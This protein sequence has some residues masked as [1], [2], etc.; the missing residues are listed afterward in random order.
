MRVVVAGLVRGESCHAFAVVPAICDRANPIVFAVC[1][2][3]T[4]LVVWGCYALAGA[5]FGSLDADRTAWANGC[6]IAL[7]ALAAVR[8]FEA[9]AFL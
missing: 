5:R 1:V 3:A 8:V 4:A 6:A 9:V 7:A 2:Q